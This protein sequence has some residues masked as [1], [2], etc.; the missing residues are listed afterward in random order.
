MV[1]LLSSTLIAALL[2]APALYAQS[3]TPDAGSSTLSLSPIVVTASRMPELLNQSTAAVSVVDKDDVQDGRPTVSLDEPLN[4]VPGVFVQNSNN[5]AQDFRIQI[6]GFGTRAAFG[7]REI[8]VLVDGLPVTSPDGQTELDDVELGTV[9]RIEVLRG[10]AS[11]LYG[12]A[13]GGVIQLFT[14][15]GPDQPYAE[16]RL[17]GGSWGLQKYLVKGGGRSGKARFFLSGSYLQLGG[18]RTHSG[19]VSGVANGKLR[20]DFTDDTDATLL[21]SAVDSPKADDAGALTR[22][23]VDANPTLAAPN[24]NKFDAGEAVQQGRIG[25]VAH[26][27]E[28]AHEFSGYAYLLYRDFENSLSFA[29]QGIVAFHRFGPGAGLR[30]SNTQSP[31]GLAQQLQIGVE[32]QYQDDARRRFDNNNGQR[33]ALQVQ[34]D[35]KVTGVGPYVRETLF[36]RDD[37]EISG[38]ARYDNVRFDVNVDRPSS[39]QGDAVR[40]FE[41]YSP[42]GGVRYSPLRWLSLFGNLSTAFQVPTTTEL[43]NALG[44][45]FTADLKPQMAT[46]YE[47][48]GRIEQSSWL[49]AEATGFYIDVDD[50]I[51]PY[52]SISSCVAGVCSGGRVSYR[53]AG[54]SRRAGAEVSWEAWL[55][56]ALRWTS[57]FSYLDSEYRDYSTATQLP[58]GSTKVNHFNGN[59]EP[60]IP[61]WRLYEELAYRH[62]SGLFAAIEAIAVDRYFVDDGNTVRSPGYE[63]VNLRA[64]LERSIG[65]FSVEPFI[66]LQN[67][68][69]TNYDGTVRLNAQFG[70][71]FEPGPALS[72]YGGLSVRAML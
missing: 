47:L 43:A 12:N 59:S 40:S 15:D 14:E 9:R 26:H 52:E 64:G 25:G 63:L 46:S 21:L 36:L 72:I 13:A 68:T 50:E 37:L 17:T 53:N 54:K 44:P 45:G 62:R 65:I 28:G 48:G 4:R 2:L 18:Y 67:I 29:A 8:K 20:Y 41:A 60:G 35:E 3:P 69:D 6:R 55:L 38:G 31:F 66:G 58:D 71:Y 61:S 51:V 19:T 56:P 33:A 22:K 11:A 34:Q 57:T 30:Y 1:R 70:R 10:P 24:N 39:L 42:T 7:T 27:R 5:F 23:E 49:R 16:A 32:V